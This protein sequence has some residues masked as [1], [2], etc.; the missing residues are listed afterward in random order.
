MWATLLFS[1]VTD[2]SAAIGKLHLEVPPTLQV[3]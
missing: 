1:L 3:V 2:A